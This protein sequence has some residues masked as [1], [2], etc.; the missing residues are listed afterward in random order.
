[1]GDTPSVK[2]ADEKVDSPTLSLSE[3]FQYT[4]GID[5]A[6]TIGAAIVAVVSGVVQARCTPMQTSP[7]ATTYSH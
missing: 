5:R 4:T 2:D 3:F 6:L 1:M 7:Y